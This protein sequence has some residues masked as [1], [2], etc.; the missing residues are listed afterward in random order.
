MIEL[1]VNAPL[2]INHAEYLIIMQRESSQEQNR[3]KYREMSLHCGTRSSYSVQ[4]KLSVVNSRQDF[5]TTMVIAIV[6]IFAGLKTDAVLE[7]YQGI[8]FND[9]ECQ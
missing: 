5:L 9:T 3:L 8:S 4:L 7:G 1:I 2:L 6:A